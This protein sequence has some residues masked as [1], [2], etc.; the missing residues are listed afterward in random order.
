MGLSDF[1]MQINNL[2]KMNDALKVS[3]RN[4]QL[5]DYQYEI[6]VKAIRNFESELDDDHEVAVK[7]ASF[8]QSITMNVTSIGYSNPSIIHF[9]GY[10]NGQ[11]AELIQHI[12]QLSF[13]L[14]SVPK[15][16]PDK[17]ARRIGFTLETD[18]LE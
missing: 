6:L 9:Y 5:A 12:N 16:E 10:V 14:A 3:I 18:S 15:A 13:L 2:A 4:P 7:L 11:H 1:N 17:P 8:G